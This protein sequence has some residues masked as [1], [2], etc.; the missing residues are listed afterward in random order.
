MIRGKNLPDWLRSF[1]YDEMGGSYEPNRVDF[2]NNLYSDE[3][4][5]KKYL[6]TYFPRSFAESYCIFIN[7]FENVE[8]INAMKGKESVTVLTFGC[9]TG[10]DLMGL[11]EAI[12]EKMPW[13]KN[14]DVTAY[15]GNFNAVVMMKSIVEHPYNQQ[16]F[17][18]VRVDYA[19]VPMTKSDDFT[20]FCEVIDKSYDFVVSLKMVNELYRND[21]IASKP[22]VTFLEK[23]APKLTEVGI[24]LL[25]DVPLMVKNN[26]LPVLMSS[27]LRE[28]LKV[29]DGYDAIAPLPCHIFGR[30]CNDRCYL[31]RTFYGDLF[32]S[33]PVTYCMLAR[34]ELAKAICEGLSN[35]NYVVNDGN[36]HCKRVSGEEEKDAFNLI[37]N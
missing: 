29:D 17:N 1:I 35:C 11:L 28:F 16:R 9:G 14:L 18:N 13:V 21:I 30:A 37:K 26:W 25:L 12:S 5:N 32:I 7:L 27:G 24:M 33:E 3:E 20:L 6:G 2:Q 23:L 4:K 15:D 22:Y 34:K 36:E 31:C 8:Y 10:G 19:P